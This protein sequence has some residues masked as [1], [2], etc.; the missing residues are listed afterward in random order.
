M[1]IHGFNQIVTTTAKAPVLSFFK[2]NITDASGAV[3]TVSQGK[4]NLI[5][6]VV[7]N[8]AG[9]YTVTFN[10]PYPLN[11]LFCDPKVHRNAISD[12]FVKMEYDVGS[13]TP[14]GSDSTMVLF[15]TNAGTTATDPPN[16]SEVHVM[17]V[18]QAIKKLVD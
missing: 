13:F 4:A 2:F 7:R 5:A 9:N 14:G 10:K 1:P 3:G 8:S 16:G 18:H 6:S 12:T 17:L 11:I 15:T